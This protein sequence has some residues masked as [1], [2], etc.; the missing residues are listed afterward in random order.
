M[1]NITVLKDESLG[2]VEREYREVKRKANVGERIKIVA[3]VDYSD[4]ENGDTFAVD[5]V[6]RDGSIFITDNTGDEEGVFDEEY[7]TLE[8]SDILRIKGARF[9]MVDRKAAVGERV[10]VTGEKATFEIGKVF[11]VEDVDWAYPAAGL[12][13]G[14]NAIDGHYRVLEPVESPED[15]PVSEPLSAKPAPDQAAELIAKLTTRVATLERRVAALEFPPIVPQDG[16]Q[17]D[18]VRAQIV[19]KLEAPKSPQEIRDD[20][21]KRAKEDLEGVKTPWN[22]NRDPQPLVYT[23]RHYVVDVE[24]IV[25]HDKRTVVA[26]ARW[27]NDGSIVSKGIAKCAPGDVFNS[28]IGRAIALRRALGL[29][30]PAEYFEAPN[31]TE[32]HVGDVVTFEYVRSYGTEYRVLSLKDGQNLIITADED[33]D[34]VGEYAFGGDRVAEGAIILDDSRESDSAEPRKEVA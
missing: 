28:H 17:L 16:G 34:M 3:G 13:D 9:H 33:E 15:A 26:L 12:R 20:I 25:N 1:T 8:P 24:F 10:V 2:G 14:H 22:V 11:V 31:P 29:E 19:A 23:F 30:V 27:R 18:A 5:R 21:V 6:G 7:V 4:Y 32:V